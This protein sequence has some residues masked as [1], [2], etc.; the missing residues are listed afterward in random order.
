MQKSFYWLCV[1]VFLLDGDIP[2]TA[3]AAWIWAV[4]Q[5]TNKKEMCVLHLSDNRLP[6]L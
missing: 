3:P 4:S 5:K 2:K 1:E 6:L